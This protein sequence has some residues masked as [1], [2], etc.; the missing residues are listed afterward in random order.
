MWSNG[1][2]NKAFSWFMDGVAGRNI[3][4]REGEQI[5][6]RISLFREDILLLP[7]QLN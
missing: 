3:V 4:G 2:V 1:T 5:Q 7:V 6:G